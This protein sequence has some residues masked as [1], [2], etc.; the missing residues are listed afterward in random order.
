MHTRIVPT[1]EKPPEEVMREQCR[2]TKLLRSKLLKELEQQSR[3]FVYSR[4]TLSNEEI[5]NIYHAT[6]SYGPNK[7]M[8]VRLCDKSHPTGS[9]EWRTERL[10]I[11]AIDRS[12]RDR[13]ELGWDISV[14]HWAHFCRIARARWQD[15]VETLSPIHAAPTA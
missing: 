3:I 10:M 8:C 9:V 11:A 2:H 7:L 4:F 1:P 12:G 6:Q 13:E 5:S 15:I 14:D